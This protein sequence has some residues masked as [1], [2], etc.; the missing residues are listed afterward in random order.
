MSKEPDMPTITVWSKPGCV[1]CNATTRT[2]NHENVPYAEN[3]LTDPKHR[4]QL[5]AFVAQG[6]REAPIVQTPTDTW[7]GFRPDKLS[8]VV[9][10]HRA[11]TPSP[12]V[13]VDG[14][15]VA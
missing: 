11:A 7:S 14:P 5:E 1:Q 13:S 4:Q 10:H 9:A 3:D 15:H 12:A 8:T 2:L 6:F